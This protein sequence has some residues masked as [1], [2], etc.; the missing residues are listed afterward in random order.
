MVFTIV[1]TFGSCFVVM[2]T[3][4][5]YEGYISSDTTCKLIVRGRRPCLT[6]LSYSFFTVDFMGEN[7]MFWNFT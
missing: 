1:V 4:K 3:V 5:V 6:L 7:Q 2:V